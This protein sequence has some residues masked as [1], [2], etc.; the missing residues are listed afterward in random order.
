MKN[1][2]EEDDDDDDDDDEEEEEEEEEEIEKEI[3]YSPFV[4]TLPYGFI[5]DGNDPTT[6]ELERLFKVSMPTNL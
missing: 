4:T 6:L 3:S 1:Q 5:R 2:K